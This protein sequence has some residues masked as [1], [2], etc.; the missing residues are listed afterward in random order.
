[1]N[2]NRYIGEATFAE[3][4]GRENNALTY[5][6]RNVVDTPYGQAMEFDGTASVDNENPHLF[7]IDPSTGSTVCMTLRVDTSGVLK[8]LIAG[9]QSQT[10]PNF[11]AYI[12]FSGANN[13]KLEVQLVSGTSFSYRIFTLGTGIPTGWSTLVFK[14]SGT[15]LTMYIN[16]QVVSG[17]S[18]IVGSNETFIRHIG[19][20]GN[21]GSF[22]GCIKD[23]I[24]FDRALSDAEILEY[25]SKE[26]F[27]YEKDI[28]CRW[29]LDNT[30]DVKD[31]SW[32]GCSHDF[33]TILG[34]P[35]VGS[36][37][38]QYEMSFDDST[39]DA[40]ESSFIYVPQV[41]TMNLMFWWCP[42]SFDHKT[43][44]Y[45]ENTIVGASN[46]NTSSL[47][48]FQ[49]FVYP[50]TVFDNN[51]RLALGGNI[52]DTGFDCSTFINE[53]HHL[54]I[55]CDTSNATVYS[56]GIKVGTYAIGA[57]YTV[58]EPLAFGKAY[59]AGGVAQN[60]L[61]KIAKPMILNRELTYPDRIEIIN[62]QLRGEL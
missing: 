27:D 55:F 29:E 22:D 40:I 38:F 51:L 34:S 43:N 16:G 50:D 35:T 42:Q 8:Y 14:F 15:A 54:A 21:S 11:N 30:T 9:F 48:G 41:T 24:V 31:I 1:M 62:K 23:M 47:R 39:S 33:S 10:A 2:I 58:D 59:G 56:D 57:N 52:Y 13:T 60:Y 44:F 17:I 45:D 36:T 6:N 53:W 5:T 28:E 20:D 12:R 19:G 37:Q 25:H 18:G 49:V 32:K 3:D 26:T 7:T 4:F 61:G 46:Q